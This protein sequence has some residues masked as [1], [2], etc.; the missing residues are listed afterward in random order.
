[1]LYCYLPYSRLFSR[2]K[3]FTNW[4]ISTFQGEKFHEQLMINGFGKISR[5]KFSQAI[6]LIREIYDLN[7]TCYTVVKLYFSYRIDLI[8]SDYSLAADGTRIVMIILKKLQL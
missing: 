3:F 2:G 1:M 4:P 6:D 7:K 8:F 5:V